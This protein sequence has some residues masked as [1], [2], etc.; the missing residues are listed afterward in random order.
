MSAHDWR[1]KIG[2]AMERIR[3]R[4]DFIGRKTGA[5][6]LAVVYP[7]EVESAFLKEWRTHCATLQ[8]EIDVRA[9]DVLD[10]TQH[11]ITEIGAANIVSS[12]ADPMPGSDP[13]SEL[14]GLW[15][16]AVAAAVEAR[17][18]ERGKGKPVVSIERLAALYP[19]AGPRDVM[20]RLWD[21]AQSVLN[22]PVVALVPGHIL[23]ARTY[24]F[25]GKRD[26]FMYRGDLL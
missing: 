7:A 16:S 20:Q 26:E 17:L 25:V 9:V 24:S 11:I 15:I 12:I 2:E 14:G 21:S 13:T 3:T 1:R 5:P 19:A 22:G 8:P 23:E 6:F 10:V 18:A 4:Y